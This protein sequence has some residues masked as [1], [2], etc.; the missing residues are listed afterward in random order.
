ML[1]SSVC[2]LL[3][4]ILLIYKVRDLNNYFYAMLSFFVIALFAYH[5]VGEWNDPRSERTPGSFYPR[6]CNDR[7]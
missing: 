2:I 6:E 4:G 1:A 7:A 3:G 5:C